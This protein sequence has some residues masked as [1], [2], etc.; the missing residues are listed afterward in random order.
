MKK[1]RYEKEREERRERLTKIF[2]FCMQKLGG[3]ETR[4]TIGGLI[5]PVARDCGKL[6]AKLEKQGILVRV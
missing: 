6:E 2:G 3:E 4:A 1:T 5:D